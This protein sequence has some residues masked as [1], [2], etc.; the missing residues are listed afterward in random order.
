[1]R[2]LRHAAAVLL[3]AAVALACVAVHRSTLGRLPLGL[4]LAVATT[5]MVA[6]ALRSS[7]AP[8]TAASYSLGWLLLLG[9]VLAGRPEGDYALASD[10]DGY[11]LIVTGFVLLV[12]AVSA[13]AAGDTHARAR[14]T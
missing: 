12:V 11:A 6:R 14:R 2:P 5:L 9:L 13:F 4:V 10:L 7:S 3:G 8:R 1:M